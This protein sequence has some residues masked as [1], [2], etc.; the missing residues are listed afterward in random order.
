[1]GKHGLSL[2]R[3]LEILHV[4]LG[5][6]SDGKVTPFYFKKEVFDATL[7]GSFG[8]GYGHVQ[9]RFTDDG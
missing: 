7:F 2:I 5:F 6:G 4:V 9:F 3:N 1:M 8:C